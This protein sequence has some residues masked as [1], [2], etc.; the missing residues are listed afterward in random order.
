M[1]TA[2]T[3]VSTAPTVVGWIL[4]ASGVTV[5]ISL[6]KLSMSYGKIAQLLADHERRI[7]RVE[8]TI[9][10]AARGTFPPSPHTRP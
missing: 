8:S 2:A 4:G 3:T 1:L 5:A 7:A 10:S 6:A 9:D